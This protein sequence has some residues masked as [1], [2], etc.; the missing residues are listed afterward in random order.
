MAT[1]SMSPEREKKSLFASY[2]LFLDQKKRREEDTQDAIRDLY[3]SGVNI[4]HTKENPRKTLNASSNKLDSFICK[5]PLSRDLLDK[6]QHQYPHI[7]RS[8]S[9]EFDGVRN[10]SSEGDAPGTPVMVAQLEEIQQAQRI[11]SPQLAAS[12][13]S[14]GPLHS[15]R[16]QRRASPRERYRARAG[17]SRKEGQEDHS[18]AVGTGTLGLDDHCAPDGG[19]RAVLRGG[20]VWELED[21]THT[22]C[23]RRE[24][25]NGAQVEGD[26]DCDEEGVPREPLPQAHER[27]RPLKSTRGFQHAITREREWTYDKTRARVLK[28]PEIRIAVSAMMECSGGKPRKRAKSAAWK[29]WDSLSANRLSQS[30]STEPT[31]KSKTSGKL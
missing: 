9:S 24:F 21:E 8:H 22:R 19:G 2:F 25:T 16:K 12:S 10:A 17:G 28:E 4:L 31:L 6:Q 30:G 14:R 27:A 5:G 29:D 1:S 23:W 26:D 3:L 18:S 7:E 20:G 13:S 11:L 15:P